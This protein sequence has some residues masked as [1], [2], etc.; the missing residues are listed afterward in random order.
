MKK[1]ILILAAILFGIS[2][3]QA[4]SVKRLLKEADEDFAYGEYTVAL[5]KYLDLLNRSQE[6]DEEQKNHLLFRIGLC[7]LN[8][9][10][11][12]LSLPYLKELHERRPDYK[13]SLPFYLAQAYQYNHKFEEALLLYEQY[14]KTQDAEKNAERH[15][16]VQKKIQE[17]NYGI[18]YMRDP[19]PVVIENIG[20]TINSRFPDYV[21]VISAD[22]SE[23]IFTSRRDNTTGGGID[24]ADGHYYED[25]YISYK[26]NGKWTVPEKL[27]PPIN[28]DS[29]DA[30]IA[31][32]PDG[33]TLFIY[34]PGQKGMGDIYMSQK[35]PDG[36]DGSWSEP[37]DLGKNINTKYREPSVSITADGKTIYF[38]SDRPGGY[39]GLDIYR[40]HLQADGSWGP[41]INLGSKINTPY[42]EDAPFIHDDTTLY[43]SSQGHTSMGGFDIF[44]STYK[45][46]EWSTPANLGYPINTADD[47]IYFVLSADNK[48][49][50]YASAKEGGYGEKDIYTIRMPSL[51]RIKKQNQSLQ[52][53][54]EVNIRK[55]DAPQQ[56]GLPPVVV[57]KGMVIDALSKQKLV[58]KVELFNL[59]DNRLE[60]EFQTSNPLG[61]FE[62]VMRAG[63]RY[64]ITAEKEGYLFH[65]EY[66]EIPAAQQYQV[67]ER[68]IPL[69]P[70]RKGAKINLMVF[71]DFDKAEL[72]PESVQELKR[73][74]ELLRRHPSLKL[75][76]AGHTDAIGTEEKNLG[77]SNRRAQAVV[78]YLVENGIAPHRL[79]AVGYGESRPIASNDTEEG[80]QLNRRTE[81]IVVDF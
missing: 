8:T 19:V 3:L 74:V 57:L 52:A 7:Y 15:R 51:E 73:L 20:P 14:L 64:L 45:N 65:S 79:K 23:L 16:T 27:P 81:C 35:K 12:D 54:V 80:R 67:V 68:T 71:F 70:L 44:M 42:D 75:E 49:G 58:A 17:C 62:S 63:Q 6:L 13:E 1:V 43:F 39:G 34:K 28:T 29:H 4:Q 21:P 55:I 59:N 76:I 32:S 56:Q 24:P 60:D 47:D 31:L 2:A 69:Q 40:S 22:E 72:R 30:C 5:P 78:D 77:L 37:V 41:A 18:Q 36:S 50:Y 48:T 38:S 46:G 26:K 11:K 66:F 53:K 33:N 61:F 9:S 10:H 25:I